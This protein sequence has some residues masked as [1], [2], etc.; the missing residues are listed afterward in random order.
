MGQ[1]QFE[2]IFNLRRPGDESFVRF[3]DPTGFLIP[4]GDGSTTDWPPASPFGGGAIGNCG[5]VV[6]GPVYQ[7]VD[8]SDQPI[9]LQ[10]VLGVDGQPTIALSLSG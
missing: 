8:F 9:I 6:V 4:A 10:T 3:F 2:N 5:Q 7:A 1:H